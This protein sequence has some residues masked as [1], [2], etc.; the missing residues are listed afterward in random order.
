[1]HEYVFKSD[2]DTRMLLPMLAHANV[3]AVKNGRMCYS[4]Q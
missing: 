1:V 3:T 2:L 4:L